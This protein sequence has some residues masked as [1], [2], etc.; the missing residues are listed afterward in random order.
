[1]RSWSCHSR[2]SQK[3]LYLKS[4]LC[5]AFSLWISE[6]LSWYI[7][8]ENIHLCVSKYKIHLGVCSD[9]KATQMK[10]LVQVIYITEC[11]QNYILNTEPAWEDWVMVVLQAKPAVSSQAQDSRKPQPL[12]STL[13][14]KQHRA[15][16][17]D[18]CRTRSFSSP[19]KCL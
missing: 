17:R 16:L 12:N 18:T 5:Y 15:V 1:M 2:K 13:F 6:Q 7:S 11:E 10:I 19:V 14:S 3:A 8:L 4:C 9:I